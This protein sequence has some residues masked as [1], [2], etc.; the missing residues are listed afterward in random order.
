[1]TPLSVFLPG[2]VV[3]RSSKATPS[4]ILLAYSFTNSIFRWFP[5]NI[6]TTDMPAQ[7]NGFILGI[8]VKNYTIW[9]IHI[10]AYIQICLE[11]TNLKDTPIRW[12][13]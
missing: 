8:C 13:P 5:L 4:A 3:P 2:K 7:T 6:L 12:D 11:T 1:M 10:R 9:D